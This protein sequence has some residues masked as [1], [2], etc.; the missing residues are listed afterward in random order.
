ML[1]LVRVTEID[2]SRFHAS[3]LDIR[4]VKTSERVHTFAYKNDDPK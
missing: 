1:S 3:Y 2:Q 4:L